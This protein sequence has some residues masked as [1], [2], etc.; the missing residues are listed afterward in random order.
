MLFISFVRHFFHPR[1]VF[2]TLI[3]NYCD[4]DWR[5]RGWFAYV[6]CLLWNIDTVFCN[7]NDF[8]IFFLLLPFAASVFF[9][10]LSVRRSFFRST[11]RLKFMIIYCYSRCTRQLSL[12]RAFCASG[13]ILL[14][15]KGKLGREKNKQT[16]FT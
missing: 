13:N 6:I 7:I 15:R 14:E 16:I 11:V 1:Y 2:M 4:Y 5:C 8:I 10:V 3:I 12:G 9:S